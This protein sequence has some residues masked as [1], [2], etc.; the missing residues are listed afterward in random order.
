MW[1]TIDSA[2]KE[3]RQMFVVKAF[4][5]QVGTTTYDSDPWCVWHDRG[6]F[7]RWPHKF[8]PTHW[9]PLPAPPDQT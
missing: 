7:Y 3:T 5:A 9:M 2:P 8:P 6:I 1:Q 4:G